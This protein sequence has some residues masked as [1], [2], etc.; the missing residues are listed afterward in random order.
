M[1]SGCSSP[2]CTTHSSRSILVSGQQQQIG[3]PLVKPNFCVF[4]CFLLLRC[5]FWSKENYIAH[6]I[7]ESIRMHQAGPQKVTS[8]TIYVDDR[9][10]QP[11]PA[12]DTSIRKRTSVSER[13]TDGFG[14]SAHITKLRLVTKLARARTNAVVDTYHLRRSSGTAPSL[15]HDSK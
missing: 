6:N 1:Q 11:K 3:L 12:T 4:G 13:H 10:Q 9:V 7:D 2:L 14:T 15:S 5:V 8:A